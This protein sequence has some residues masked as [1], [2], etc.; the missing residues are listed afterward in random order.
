MNSPAITNFTH[1]CG[2]G[3][4]VSTRGH[5]CAECQPAPVRKMRRAVALMVD[6]VEMHCPSEEAENDA[7]FDADVQVDQ[8]RL[9]GRRS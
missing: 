9:D 8:D 4:P 5:L 3:E 6:A 1:L 2:C 7:A